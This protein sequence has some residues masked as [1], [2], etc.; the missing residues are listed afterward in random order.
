MPR[1]S[2]DVA[3]IAELIAV[4]FFLYITELM[5]ISHNSP[6]DITE[7]EYGN[8]RILG[9]IFVFRSCLLHRPVLIP[10]LI[11]ITSFSDSIS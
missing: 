8:G 4:L 5:I 6:K 9:S 7:D 11:E 1:G 10:S 2:F 3:I